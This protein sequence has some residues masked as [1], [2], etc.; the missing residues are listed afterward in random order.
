[1]AACSAQWFATAAQDRAIA[2]QN[3]SFFPLSIPHWLSKKCLAV[4]V[5][6]GGYYGMTGVLVRHSVQVQ[7]RSFSPT[8]ITVH[9]LLH[10][11]R[12]WDHSTEFR[13]TN[14]IPICTFVRRLQQNG[15]S[16]RPLK[17]V[18]RLKSSDVGQ[19]HS[20]IVIDINCGTTRSLMSGNE[21]IYIC[22][23][24]VLVM[25]SLASSGISNEQT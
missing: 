12:N 18:K 13:E 16:T 1:M 20:K 15:V 14:Q 17:Q 22:P 24:V 23:N 9:F 5:Y 8:L 19:I 10:P 3:S 21:A 6:F 11:L 2:R 4:E 7:K 25:S